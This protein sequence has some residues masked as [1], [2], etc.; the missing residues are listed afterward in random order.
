M[1]TRVVSFAG[2][3]VAI[4]YTGEDAQDI[5]GFL[6]RDLG[7][8]GH[9][10]PQIKLEIRAVADE[11]KVSLYCGDS[12]LYEGTSRTG[13]ANILMAEIIRHLIDKNDKGMALHAGALS[14]NGKGIM[15]PGK[16]GSGKSTL[17]AWLT[18]RGYNYLTDELV[19]IGEGADTLQAF[20][21]P[22][23]IKASAFSA[24]KKEVDLSII[25][26]LAFSSSHIALVPHRLLNRNYKRE[27]PTVT[28]ILFPRH[29]PDAALE[30]KPLSKG[31]A[32]LALMEC[33]VNARNLNG[34]GLGEA[35]RIAGSAPAYR[36]TYSR[37]DQ[38]GRTIDQL[39]D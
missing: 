31:Q 18:G 32:A 26:K 36:I 1:E 30:L 28:L 14:R 5:V 35:I 7:S 10:E 23:S 15:L 19:F 8:D 17:T 3:S 16:S 11:D 9:I 37:F 29:Q 21:R 34:H 33:L 38:L 27:V 39:V 13:L 6:C 25:A 4:A 22:I 24:M 12:R 20:T 2:R